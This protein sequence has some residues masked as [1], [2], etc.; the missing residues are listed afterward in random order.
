M[1]EFIQEYGSWFVSAIT[2]IYI[3]WEK[4]SGVAK[5]MTEVASISAENQL[6]LIKEVKFLKRELNEILENRKYSITLVFTLGK[7]PQVDSI[8]IKPV[9]VKRAVAK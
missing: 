1:G 9:K 7:V 6:D 5:T 3:M 8:S 4:K 2:L